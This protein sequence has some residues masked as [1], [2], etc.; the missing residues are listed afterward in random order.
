M[1]QNISSY[2]TFLTKHCTRESLNLINISACFSPA[3]LIIRILAPKTEKWGQDPNNEQCIY[4][5]LIIRILAPYLFLRYWGQDPNNE[6]CL[7]NIAY[8]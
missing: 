4:T 8:Y 6:Q 3:L 7:Y 1:S 2:K 5:L